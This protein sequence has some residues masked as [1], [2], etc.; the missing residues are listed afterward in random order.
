MKI[1]AMTKTYG[2]RIVADTPELVLESG[3]IT[4]VIGP[5]GSG[6]STFS[7]MAA[8]V[9]A[10]DDRHTAFEKDRTVRYMPQKSY[11]F[12]MS[13]R[14]NIM[15]SG[16]EPARAEK[17][18]EALGLDGLLHQRIRSLSGGETAKIAFIRVLMKPCDLL[19]LDEP[20]AAMDMESAITSER[21]LK[22]YLEETGCSVLLVTHDLQQARRLA[23]DALF[24]YQGKLCERGSAA[25]VLFEPDDEVTRR[26]LNYYGSSKG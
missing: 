10:P 3:R 26:F 14:Q 5:N 17:M 23:D 20:T 4:A 2:K 1:P 9:L 21:L 16:G 13:V 22:D 8:G 19:I 11:P 24:F 15:L 25:K 7:R 12:R 18:M 6:K